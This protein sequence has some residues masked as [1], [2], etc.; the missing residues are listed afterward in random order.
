ME[1][2]YFGY[3]HKYV[4]SS[5]AALATYIGSTI[6]SLATRSDSHKDLTI[7]TVKDLCSSV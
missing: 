1:L 3:N 5:P 6:P 2:K 7:E 4:S